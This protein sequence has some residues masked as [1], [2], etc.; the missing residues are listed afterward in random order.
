MSDQPCRIPIPPHPRLRGRCRNGDGKSVRARGQ[1]ET[2]KG[3]PLA[4]MWVLH[5][6][7]V[8]YLSE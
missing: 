7:A 8:L 4:V 5:E 3:W 6:L 2:V 1:E